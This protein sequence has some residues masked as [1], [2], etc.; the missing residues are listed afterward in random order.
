MGKTLN[1][2][3]RIYSKF[4]ESRVL[5]RIIGYENCL[6]IG[7]LERPHYG[8]CVYHAAILAKKL[9]INR[10]S[11]LELGVAG[12]NGLLNLEY[13][14]HQVTKCVDIEIDVYGFDTECGLPSSLD[15]RDQ[16][17]LYEKGSY[18]ID[19]QKLRNRLKTAKLVLGDIKDTIRF[20]FKEYDPAPIGAIA[21]DMDYYSSTR[22]SLEM[23]KANEKYFLPRMFCYFDDVSGNEWSLNNEF[24]GERLAISEFNESHETMKFAKAH[25]LLSRRIVRPWYHKIWIYHNF[26]HRKYNVFIANTNIQNSLRTRA[27]GG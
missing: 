19:V 2:F 20:F 8:Y 14:A 15:Y 25:Y 4:V 13:H 21:F 10:I 5:S 16:P 24:T 3:R 26:R 22:D 11:V 23:F 12:G 1:L 9:G 27:P 6:K 7:V 18:N 17:Y